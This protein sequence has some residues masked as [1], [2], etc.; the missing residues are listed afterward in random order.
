MFSTFVHDKYIQSDQPVKK[1]SKEQVIKGEIMNCL[2]G[3]RYLRV[4]TCSFHL[5]AY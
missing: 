4:S 1:I 3:E 2:V 5:F